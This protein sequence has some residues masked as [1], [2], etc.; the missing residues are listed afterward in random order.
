MMRKL[1]SNEIAIKFNVSGRN[2]RGKEE[3]MKFEGTA[4]YIVLKGI[5][6]T[7]KI[8]TFSLLFVINSHFIFVQLHSGVIQ[9]P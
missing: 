8:T 1:L 9:K 2:R 5:I 6:F 4:A 3:K 7:Y